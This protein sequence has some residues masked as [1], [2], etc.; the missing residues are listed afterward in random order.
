[1]TIIVPIFEKPLLG[2]TF[3]DRD[4]LQVHRDVGDENLIRYGVPRQPVLRARTRQ[5]REFV[6]HIVIVIVSV[7][8]QL[9]IARFALALRAVGLRADFGFLRRRRHGR[10]GGRPL[11]VGPRRHRL[12]R[13]RLFRRGVGQSG[14]EGAAT[15]VSRGSGRRGGQNGGTRRRGDRRRGFFFAFLAAVGAVR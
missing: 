14:V 5:H 7:H 9:F 11:V 10:L 1:M 13:R 6:S 8:R 2:F 15:L 12:R 4:S 3:P